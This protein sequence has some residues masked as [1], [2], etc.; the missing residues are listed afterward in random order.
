MADRTRIL[1]VEDQEADFEL[2]WREVRKLL[3]QS[4]FQRVENAEAFLEALTA[5]EPDLI[6]SD[7]SMPLFDGL[8]ALKLARQHRPDTPVVIYTCA[9]NE[10]TAVE[11]M[12]A[13][14]A[15]YVIKE[16]SKRLGPAVVRS[17][18]EKQER[19]RRR[20]AE[21]ALTESNE[22]LRYLA[23]NIDSLLFVLDLDGPKLRLSYLSPA[24]E[25]VWG[26]DSE[27]FYRDPLCWLENV[28][29]EDRP[30]VEQ[31]VNQISTRAA[32]EIEVQYRAQRPDGM[33]WV[34]VKAKTVHV[35]PNGQVR[36]VGLAEDITARRVAEEANARLQAQLAQAQKMETVGQL[37]GGVAHDFNNLIGVILGYAE[38]LQEKL[39]G[40]GEVL[41]ELAEIERASERARNLTRQLLAFSRK[42]MIAPQILSL[43]QHIVGVLQALA[44]LIRED[45]D[46]RFEPGEPLWNVKFDPS[47]LD[48]VLVN[49]AVNAR[50]AMPGGGTLLIATCNW[51]QDAAR[52]MAVPKMAAG[53]YV[54]LSV[55]DTGV[56]M[57][58]VVLSH[59]FEP[60]F[61]TKNLGEG[62]GLGLSTVYGI[63]AQNGSYIDVHSAPGQGS[64]FRIA[65][66]R[67]LQPATQPPQ[68]TG[69]A[70]RG[71]GRI[72]LAEDDEQVREMV[73]EMLQSL[74]YT[75]SVAAT[76][77]EALSLN[78]YAEV[79][80]DL[81]LTDV[82]MP[83]LSGPELAERIRLVR[84]EMRVIYM[85]GYASDP[86]LKL[87]APADGALRIQKPFDSRTL[88][89]AVKDVLRY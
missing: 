26:R 14:A 4:D 71:S 58:P 1:V 75:V 52:L 43:N 76:P 32:A 62:T 55:R 45:I 23:E 50:D 74:G 72:L 70:S 80:Y 85:S 61:T 81:L 78:A 65:I 34:H 86:V 38:L 82:V 11:C 3:P 19:L 30:C 69:P 20:D 83:R 17:L 48:Q 22:R 79:S 39:A 40:R 6:V 8:S 56:G 84:P 12:K 67:S 63:V 64:T 60:F 54:L 18:E 49:L 35:G 88:A 16:H 33:R 87:R 73:A 31:A 29:E 2:A 44:R 24:C 36:V 5:F 66:P 21:E 57:S 53:D 37:A 7:Y 13:G 47:Q 25:H 9:I 46:L 42:Q 15:D 28:H 41:R 89:Q 77:E 27:Q 59:I 51:P 10:D 68:R